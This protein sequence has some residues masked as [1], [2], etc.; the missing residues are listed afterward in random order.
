MPEFFNVLAPDAAFEVLRQH[1]SPLESEEI[2][3]SSALDRV[4]AK[5]IRSP[6]VLPSSAASPQQLR[7]LSD[8]RGFAQSRSARR[9][10]SSR[11]PEISSRLSG[12]SSARYLR[13]L[14]KLPLVG[15]TNRLL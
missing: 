14:L 5:E 15:R 12:P 1:L 6:E 2:K 9:F 11:G 3:T 7:N 10:G 13:M 8:F 4:T